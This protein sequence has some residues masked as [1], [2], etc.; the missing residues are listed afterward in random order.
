M[1]KVHCLKWGAL[2]NSMFY[3]STS[4]SSGANA[5][6]QNERIKKKIDRKTLQQLE[7]VYKVSYS[8]TA[9]F[10]FL[11]NRDHQPHEVS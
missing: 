3:M 1:H 2:G 6:L 7:I 8:T 5:V 10:G 9:S 11:E 4:Q